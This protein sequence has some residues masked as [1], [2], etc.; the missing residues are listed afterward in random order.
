MRILTIVLAILSLSSCQEKSFE[1]RRPSDQIRFVNFVKEL[2]DT[3]NSSESNKVMRNALLENG[4][5]TLKLYVKDT[6]R[7]TFKAWQAKVLDI[8][9]NYANTGSIELKLGLGFDP[10]DSSEKSKNQSIVFSSIIQQSDLAIIETIK[11]IQIGEF[12]QIRGEFIE[13]KGFIDIDSYSRYKFSKNIF[14]NPEFKTRLK[15]IEKIK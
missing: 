9:E 2:R 10:A 6:L 5:P 15:A 13:K 11:P 7:L 14:D 4:I 12:V 1:D 3:V 8:T